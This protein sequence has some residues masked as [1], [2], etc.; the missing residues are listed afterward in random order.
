MTAS[1]LKGLHRWLTNLSALAVLLGVLIACLYSWIAIS[2]PEGTRLAFGV[3]LATVL[4]GNNVIGDREEQRRLSTLRKLGD[5]ELEPSEAHLLAAANEVMRLPEVSFWL[6]LV[7]LVLGALVTAGAWSLVCEL[8][9][10]V[11]AR[12]AFI[13]VV[14]APLT[15]SMAL[16]VSMP[17]ARVVLKAL[18][19]AGLP[20]TKLYEGVPSR[21]SLQRRLMS[22]AAISLFSPLALVAEFSLSR[23]RAL[24]DRLVFAAEPAEMQVILDEQRAAGLAPMIGLVLLVVFVVSV[25]AWLAG[26]MVGGPLEAL[27]GETKRLADGRYGAP[28]LVAGEYEAWAAAGAIAGL[29]AQLVALLGQLKHAAGAIGGATTTLADGDGAGPR[30]ALQRANLD[31]TSATTQELAR[32]AREIAGNAHRVSELAAATLAAART[33]RDSADGFLAAMS[34][35]REGNQAIADSVVRLNKRVQQVGRIIEFIN[36]I[37]DKSDLLALNAELEGNK[38][39]EVGRGFSLVAAEMRRLAESVMQSTQEIGRLIDEIRDATNAAVMATEAGVK[40]TDAGAALAQRVGEGLSRIVD[41]ANQS[42]SAMQNI[43]LAT[44]QQQVGTD[45]L[46]EAMNDILRSTEASSV[47][48]RE[49]RDSHDQ[50]VSLARDL[51]D[52]VVGFEVKS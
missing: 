20:V 52:T 4:V 10:G 36:G 8:P 30:F 47:A 22:Y 27:A 26:S 38:A 43:S 31:A 25:T 48:A 12:V 5:G 19:A 41:D 42:S 40:A 14:I 39:G 45:Q 13:G 16:L 49:M 51:E 17:R 29:E 11:A 24:L 7:F 3:I 44:S 1:P 32:S 33:G 35:V 46:V 50:L 2:F 23:L 37:A 21:F 18:V 34:Q 9:P 6:C 28:R 15:A